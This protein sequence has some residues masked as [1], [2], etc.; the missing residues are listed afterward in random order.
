MG[1]GTIRMKHWNKNAKSIYHDGKQYYYKH[2]HFR[3]YSTN[4]NKRGALIGTWTRMQNNTNDDGSL[5]E[6]VAEKLMELTQL[7]YP[8]RYLSKTLRYMHTKTR[9]NVWLRC[10]HW[11]ACKGFHMHWMARSRATKTLTK[12]T[13]NFLHTIIH[14]ARSK[15]LK[16]TVLC[17]VYWIWW[18]AVPRSE[19]QRGGE[20]QAYVGHRHPTT[21]LKWFDDSINL[22]LDG[23]KIGWEGGWPGTRSCN[24]KQYDRLHKVGRL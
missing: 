4:H 11:Y 10:M 15:L 8:Q 14:Y 7:E 20:V 19:S 22:S 16:Y 9:S 5:Q 17:I 1:D 3:S 18:W 2:Q 6:A 24:I 12:T 13:K 23:H 21:R